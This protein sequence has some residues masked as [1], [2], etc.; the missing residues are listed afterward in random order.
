MPDIGR[1]GTSVFATGV[2][3]TPFLPRISDGVPRGLPGMMAEAGLLD[4]THPD[5]PPIGG[6]LAMIQDYMRNNPGGASR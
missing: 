1:G 2:P 5:Q 4:P 6:L 3:P